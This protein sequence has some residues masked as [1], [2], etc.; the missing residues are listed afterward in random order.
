MFAALASAGCMVQGT[1]LEDLGT[2]RQGLQPFNTGVYDVFIEDSL[3]TAAM[4]SG[5]DWGAAFRK[6]LTDS[7]S[8]KLRLACN[9]TY[10]IQTTVEICRPVVIQGCGASTIIQAASGVTPFKVRYAGGNCNPPTLTGG[11][12]RF[13]DL[14]IREASAASVVRF[15]VWAEAAVHLQ[16]VT[17]NGFSNGV[18]IDADLSRSGS[19]QSQANGWSLERVAISNAEHAGMVTFGRDATAGLA[20]NV[21][22]RDNCAQT[23]KIGV[24]GGPLY[25]VYGSTPAF[26]AC[27]GAVDASFGG[28]VWTA[29]WSSGTAGSF[30]GARFEGFDANPAVAGIGPEDDSG[31]AVCLGCRKDETVSSVLSTNAI[32]IGNRSAYTGKGDGTGEGVSLTSG[33]VMKNVTLRGATLHPLD[34]SGTDDT[35]PLLLIALAD[36]TVMH[37]EQ[38]G[39]LDMRGSWKG[40]NSFV[41]WRWYASPAAFSPT[42]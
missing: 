28:S 41:G 27:A 15:G 42:P 26:P 8:Q 17:I 34:L 11:N 33:H 18:R 19:A 32:G 14:A 1:A 39:P 37:W 24:G 29:L 5:S 38:N 3:F 2:E 20:E 6:F 22:V 36:G 30:P 13:E 35:D 40:A 7:V 9:K 10:T 23:T 4:G 16:D 25:P 31:H 21:R 12:T